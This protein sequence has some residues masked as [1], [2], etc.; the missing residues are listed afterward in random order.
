MI[1]SCRRLSLVLDELTFSV[2]KREVSIQ[3]WI[4]KFEER[5]LTLIGFSSFSE[6]F[7]LLCLADFNVLRTTNFR[8]SMSCRLPF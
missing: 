2:E 1:S 3:V 7:E 6:S 5:A 4:G 8:A